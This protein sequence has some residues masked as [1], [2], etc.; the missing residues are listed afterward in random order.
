MPN[1]PKTLEFSTK[2]NSN[3]TYG[4]HSAID[5]VEAGLLEVKSEHDILV[6]HN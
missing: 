1:L 3:F 6:S 5:K 2:G 4:A